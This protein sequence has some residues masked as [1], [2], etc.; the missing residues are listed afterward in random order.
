V[1]N[2]RVTIIT[3]IKEEFEAVREFLVQTSDITDPATGYV[4]LTAVFP[5]RANR[6]NCALAWDVCLPTW[7]TA[8]NIFSGIKAGIISSVTQPD[9]LLMIGC[10]GGIPDKVNLYDVVVGSRIWY[11]EPGVVEGKDLISRPDMARPTKR[12]FERAQLEATDQRWLAYLRPNI[13]NEEISVRA[14]PIAAGEL[15][16]KAS[17]GDYLAHVKRASPRAIAVE[18]EGFGVMIA[19][20]EANVSA[21]VIRGISDLL[22]DKKDPPPL[23]GRVPM[24]DPNQERATRHAAAFA[25]C[26]LDNLDITHLMS[27]SISMRQSLSRLTVTID[28]DLKDSDAL[29]AALKQL[30]IDGTIHDYKVS[31]GSLIADLSLDASTAHIIK[32]CFDLGLLTKLGGFTI[33]TMMIEEGTISD[34]AASFAQELRDVVA[35]DRNPLRIAAFL[36]GKREIYPQFVPLID[37]ILAQSEAN[38][39]YTDPSDKVA[40]ARPSFESDSNKIRGRLSRLFAARSGHFLRG[41]R[42]D[43]D[44]DLLELFNRKHHNIFFLWP[45]LQDVLAIMS[46]SPPDFIKNYYSDR[47]EDDSPEIK[48]LQQIINGSTGTLG[49]CALLG[50]AANRLLREQ[51][52]QETIILPA[53]YFAGERLSGYDRE[54][55]PRRL[56]SA[57]MSAAL[58][59]QILHG[60]AVTV[61]IAD[62]AKNIFNSDKEFRNRVE[63]FFWLIPR[64]RSVRVARYLVDLHRNGLLMPSKPFA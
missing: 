20:H 29:F 64:K 62:Q 27:N 39:V 16:L 11:Y 10:A 19:A 38:L 56:E 14:E 23:Q 60:Y 46:L 1:R 61:D 35:N 26:V 30:L 43:T 18:Q 45:R 41:V 37:T 55:I 63:Q 50:E 8:G 28:A 21:M 6:P 53:L 22:A 15:L 17:S 42:I 13:P 31:R 33:S 36:G 59:N 4:Y 5:S 2:P 25:F 12:L 34:D 51:D 32:T 54:R 7:S 44:L 40:D 58:A 3:A 47:V 48:R 57:G 9:I 24:R 49:R 52:S